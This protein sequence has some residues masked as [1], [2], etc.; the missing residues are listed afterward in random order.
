MTYD[1]NDFNSF[2]RLSCSLVSL[3]CEVTVWGFWPLEKIGCL[4]FSY[5]FLGVLYIFFFFTLLKEL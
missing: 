1:V 3:F 4:L 5:F 2:S